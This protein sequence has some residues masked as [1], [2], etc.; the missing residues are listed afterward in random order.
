MDRIEPINNAMGRMETS[1]NIWFDPPKLFKKKGMN[2]TVKP[3]IVA[4]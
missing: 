4:A 1:C 2:N 3:I